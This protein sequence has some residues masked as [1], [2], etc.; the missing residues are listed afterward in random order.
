MLTF[1]DSLPYTGKCEEPNIRG[2]L[3]GRLRDARTLRTPRQKAPLELFI[4]GTTCAL[5]TLPIIS[6]SET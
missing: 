6:P 1:F 2:A 4:A 3:L 5:A